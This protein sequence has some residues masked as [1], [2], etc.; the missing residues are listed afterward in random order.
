MREYGLGKKFF[1]PNVIKKKSVKLINEQKYVIIIKLM[2]RYFI[3]FF[4][5]KL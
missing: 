2:P 4:N 3:L 1:A 5:C